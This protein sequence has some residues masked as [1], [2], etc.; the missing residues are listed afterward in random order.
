MRQLDEVDDMP[1][2]RTGGPEEPVVEVS[3]DPSHKQPDRKSLGKVR[4]LRS[5]TKTQASS[6]TIAKMLSARVIDVPRLKAA[7]GL[8]VRLNRSRVPTT[9]TGRPRR[10]G[11]QHGPLGGLI[12][13]QPQQGDTNGK[14]GREPAVQ[15]RS[16]RCLQATHIVAR[17]KT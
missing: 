17:G 13:S 6:A 1:Q 7:P 11:A 2:Q 9:S 8:K 15:R 10:E 14:Q 12:R 4:T 5:A 16:S 3:R